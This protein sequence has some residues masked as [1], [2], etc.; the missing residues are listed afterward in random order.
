MKPADQYVMSRIGIARTLIFTSVGWS[1]L[2]KCIIS[3]SGCMV[4]GFILSRRVRKQRGTCYIKVF[5]GYLGF[6]RGNAT[7]KA[8]VRNYSSSKQNSVHRGSRAIAIRGEQ[9]YYPLQHILS[10]SSEIL[11]ANGTLCVILWFMLNTKLFFCI[12][13]SFCVFIVFI[14]LLTFWSK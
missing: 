8:N 11:G 7:F 5:S 9:L 6:K 3:G 2:W 13:Y 14:C 10:I 12:I 1:R 4:L